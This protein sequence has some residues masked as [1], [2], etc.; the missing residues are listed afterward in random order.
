LWREKA[1]TLR[2]FVA[3]HALPKTV[4]KE[5]PVLAAWRADGRV[6]SATDA[7]AHDGVANAID[8]A[9]ITVVA[10]NLVA[11]HACI[12]AGRGAHPAR[13]RNASRPTKTASAT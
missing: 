11:V 8:R 3:G 1:G 12:T 5:S 2:V 9:L 4:A 10:A 7:G 6:V 13:A